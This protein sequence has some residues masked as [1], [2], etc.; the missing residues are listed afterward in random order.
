[1]ITRSTFLLQKSETFMQM[2]KILQKFNFD[3]LL[4]K[5]YKNWYL[6]L[7]FEQVTLGS[8]VLIEKNFE[9]K[10]SNV[11]LESYLE[12]KKIIFEIEKILSESFSYSKINYHMLMMNDSE[13]HFHI[14][15]RYKDSIIWNKK[16]FQDFDWAKP[17]NLSICNVLDDD[18]LFI[19]RDHLKLKFQ[20]FDKN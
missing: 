12:L 20:N 5:E 2:N 16:K 15:P 10:F 11:K 3:N 13:V 8:L 1:M 14:I 19:I 18:T 4:L 7:R 6:L 9:T 17:S